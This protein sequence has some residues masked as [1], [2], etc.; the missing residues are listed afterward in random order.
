MAGKTGLLA[1]TAGAV[2]NVDAHVSVPAVGLTEPGQ[3]VAY[4][5]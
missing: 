4:D 1:G 5:R 3:M 2:A